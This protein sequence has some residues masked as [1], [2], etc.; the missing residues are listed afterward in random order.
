L[1]VKNDKH[2]YINEEIM[3]KMFRKSILAAA[4]ALPMAAQAGG[5]YLYEVGTSDLGFAGAG[6]AA[7]AEDAST[8]YANPAGMTRLA[9]DQMTIGGQVL[10]GRAK[11]E[12]D[13]TGLL[14]GGDPDNAIG[15]LP[16]ASAFY[17]HSISD[18]LKVG[19]A[20]YGNFGLALDF[21]NDWA[22]RNL[23]E[24]TALM[25]LTLQPTIAYRINEQWSVGAGLTANFGLFKIERLA[26]GGGKRKEDDTD[27][28]YGARLGVMYEPSAATRFGLVWNSKTEYNF[29][30][31][32][33]VRGILPGV[34]HSLPISA[35][36]T[37]PQQL[38][39][40]AYHRLNDR[41]AMTGN[42]GWQDWS[43]FGNTTLEVNGATTTSSMQVQDTWHA[44]LGAQYSYNANTRVNAGIAYDTSFYKS[45]N[46]TSFALP[47]GATWRFGTGVQYTLS[48]KSDLGVAFE[49]ARAEGQRDPSRLVSGEYDKAEMLFMSVHYSQRF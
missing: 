9:G 2:C 23:T 22:G 21:G 24:K 32:A 39:A 43:E 35:E 15:W 42:I 3:N 4:I 40:S 46:R 29:D 27:W 33:T 41:W 6:T 37:A 25:A 36:I 31:D 8:V 20:T 47:S 11:F 34:N 16:A 48:P 44:A 12:L 7:R 14:P 30:V 13:G 18:R 38:M 5:L 1:R 26:L 19:I 17:S 45:Q 28:A 49:F 10:Y